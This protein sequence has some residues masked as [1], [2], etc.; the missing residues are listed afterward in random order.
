M[1]AATGLRRSRMEHACM[2][3]VGNTLILLLVADDEY[4]WLNFG[5]VSQSQRRLFCQVRRRYFSVAYAKAQVNFLL[6]CPLYNLNHNEYVTRKKF[7]K[8]NQFACK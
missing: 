1:K 2:D 3:Q 8:K 6:L 5:Y 4:S 7:R